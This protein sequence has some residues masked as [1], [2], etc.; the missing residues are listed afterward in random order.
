MGLENSWYSGAPWL[1]LLVPLEWI[2]RTLSRRRR[3]RLSLPESQ[4]RAPV[5]VIIVGNISVGGSGKTPLTLSLIDK[6]RARGYRPGVVSRGYGTKA[7]HYPFYVTA[8]T[9]PEQG[10][11]EPCLIVRRSGVPLVIDPDR[12]QAVR[13]LL[14]SSDV[15]IVISDDGLQHYRLG[16]D[17][18]LAVVDASR[19][20]G[21]ARC[22]P[23]G[24]LRE[25]PERLH[26]VDRVILNGHGRFDFPGAS[27]M[28]LKPGELT[29]LASGKTL[30]PSQ[31]SGPQQVHAVAGIGHPQR[32][33]DTLAG[34]GL[35]PLPHPLADHAAITEESISFEDDLPVIMTEKDAVKCDAW[36][37]PGVWALTV[38]AQL[39]KEF[40]DWLDQQLVRLQQKYGSP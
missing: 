40:D 26:E 23:A 36:V 2:Y 12:P 4:W 8:E 17:L 14:A 5:P 10:G 22:L 19:G 21:N 38:D 34:F 24:P 15:N 35:D 37:G 13:A 29:E 1:R 30:A 25:P 39:D 11:D 28:E 9:T 32:F 20:L 6:L 3:Q 31:W 18:E 7:P 33:F 27:T 16:R